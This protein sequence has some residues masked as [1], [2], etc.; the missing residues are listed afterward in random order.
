MCVS[1]SRGGA[2]VAPRAPRQSGHEMSVI[3]EDKAGPFVSQSVLKDS[4]C[5]VTI[6]LLDK[7]ALVWLQPTEIWVSRF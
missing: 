2:A 3:P 1:V 4:L 5:C 7:L 6:T